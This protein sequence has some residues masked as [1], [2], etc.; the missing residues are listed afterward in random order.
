[1]GGLSCRNQA[2]REGRAIRIACESAVPGRP[3]VTNFLLKEK[4]SQKRGRREMPGEP[5]M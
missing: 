3:Q 1:M 2:K 4:K 5:P